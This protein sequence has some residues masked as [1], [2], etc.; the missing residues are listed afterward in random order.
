MLAEVQGLKQRTMVELWI[1][2]R[3]ADIEALS[4]ADRAEFGAAVEASLEALPEVT[5]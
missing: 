3:A 2:D 4:P 5:P 1:E